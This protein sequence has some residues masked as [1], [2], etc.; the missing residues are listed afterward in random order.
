[1]AFKTM[2]PIA[3]PQCT[4]EGLG[5][6]TLVR[7]V[8]ARRLRITLKADKTVTVTLPATVRIAEA[9]AFVREKLPWIQKHRDRLDRRE[10]PAPPVDLKGIDLVQAQK[11]LF[12][13]LRHFSETHRLPYRRAA[14]RCQKTL[15]G[16]CS[17]NNTISL[18]INL[19]LLPQDL[20]DY[21]LLHELAHTKIKN[22]SAAFWT[23]LDTLTGSPSRL[24]ARRLKQHR[25][26][27]TRRG[28][29]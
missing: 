1:M 29:I 6:I 21:V 26:Q 18:N 5:V 11:A 4:I 8:R 17:H 19:V 23:Y 2:E 24:L 12:A 10:P 9:Q 22:H 15:W 20:Q 7:S 3:N 27:L 16:S 25:L 13:R 14:F 28:T